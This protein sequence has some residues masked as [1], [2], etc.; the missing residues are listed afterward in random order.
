[1]VVYVGKLGMWYLDAEMVRFF[2][3]AHRHDPRSFLQVLTGSPSDDLRRALTAAGVPPDA[4]DVRAV[5]PDE[6]PALLRAADAG[7]SLIRPCPS[8][9]SSSPTKV[10]EYLAAG[11]PVVST[12]G[13]GDCDRQLAGGRGVLLASLDDV[14]YDAGARTL[15]LLLDD[16]ATRAR[17]RAY[18]EAELSLA[19][20]GGPRYAALYARALAGPT[21]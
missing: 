18:A 9:R 5:R 4:F 16:P 6:V 15:S 10:G 14:A 12:A 3:A 17:C 13:I 2:A 11:L 21:G 7:L 1:V 19:R 8:K 20:T